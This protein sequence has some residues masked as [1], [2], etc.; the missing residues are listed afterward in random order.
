MRPIHGNEGPIV[1]QRYPRVRLGTG[2]SGL[3]RGLRQHGGAACAGPQC[4][5]PRLRRVRTLP[6]NRFKEVRQGTL[7]TYL[8]MARLRGN[9]T[10]RGNCVVDRIAI[11]GDKATGVTWQGPGGIRGGTSGPDRVVGRRL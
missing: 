4:G 7:N 9:L 3:R 6:H 8:R 2:Q 11:A 1:I 10:I 5:W